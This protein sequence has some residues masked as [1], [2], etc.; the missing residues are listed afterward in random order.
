MRYCNNC[1]QM[2]EPR[3][4][5]NVGVLLVLL[6]FGIIGGIIYYC[7]TPSTCPMCNSENWGVENKEYIM[8]TKK[9]VQSSKKGR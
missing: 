4:H 2:V 5:L 7:V 8:L 6:L 1:K 9:P 3:K